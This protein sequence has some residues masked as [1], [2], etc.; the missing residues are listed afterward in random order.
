LQGLDCGKLIGRGFL[1]SLD[2]R[3]EAGHC[4]EDPVGGSDS[5]DRDGVVVEPEGVGDALATGVGH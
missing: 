4:V 1:H 5:G 3:S 2:C